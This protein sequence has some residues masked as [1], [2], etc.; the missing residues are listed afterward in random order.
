M[1]VFHF[2]CD[3]D[4]GFVLRGA[5]YCCPLRLSLERL[6]YR[7]L[8]PVQAFLLRPGWSSLHRLLRV[9]CPCCSIGDLSTSPCG[10]LQ[11]VPALL[12]KQCIRQPVGTLQLSLC[13]ANQA[14]RHVLID[15]IVSEAPG[16]SDQN[17]RV[18]GLGQLPTVPLICFLPP[19]ESPVYRAR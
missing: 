6:V 11:Q 3:V 5:A 1:Q 7:P 18:F 8:R 16:V 12:T 13:L 19:H 9:R 4:H 2:L 14:G 15:E 10:K 17:S